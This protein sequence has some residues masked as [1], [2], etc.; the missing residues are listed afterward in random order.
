MVGWLV[1]ACERCSACV[2]VFES[3]VGGGTEI[4]GI[5]ISADWALTCSWRDE[6]VDTELGQE[7]DGC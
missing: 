4:K 3:G 7:D 2:I 1:L 6:G 5:M